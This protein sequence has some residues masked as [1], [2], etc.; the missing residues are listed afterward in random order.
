MYVFVGPCLSVIT[1]QSI[2]FDIAVSFFSK[3]NRSNKVYCYNGTGGLYVSI[4]NNINLFFKFLV[5]II[6][7]RRN[8]KCLYLT[9]SRSLQGFLRDF[10]FVICCKVFGIK[11]V[12]HLH[13]ADF[14]S[15][16]NSL[17]LILRWFV[18][19]VYSNIE[20]SIVG[21]PSMVE[22]YNLYPKMETAVVS[23]CFIPFS[24]EVPERK[25]NSG[26][27]LK[28]L[29][30]SN[31]MVSKGIFELIDAVDQLVKDG[32]EISLDI[33]GAPMA[34]E[35]CSKR[36]VWSKF[37]SKINGCPFIR[38][39]GTV[40]GEA[41]EKLL[42]NSDLFALPSYYKTESQ[43]ISIIE[44]IA[45]GCV[46]VCSRHNYLSEMVNENN[47][48][49]FD[50]RSSL[51]ISDLLCSL[52]CD[53]S[54]FNDISAYNIQYASKHYTMSNYLLKIDEVLRSV[55]GNEP[56]LSQKKTDHSILMQGKDSQDP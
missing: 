24:I 21:L 2:A 30:L 20:M 14:K 40:S 36:E 27:E 4:V 22:Q 17:P 54:T 34:D 3:H 43:P 39:H 7:H 48:Y 49:L 53:R 19:F 9:T 28:V 41:K 31:L 6:R 1:G 11:V 18:D 32:Y 8:V 45:A 38:Y 51:S 55:C 42:F 29:F 46:I 56:S 52:H 47:G 33:A 25:F 16:R 5:Y 37:V 12:N 50:K 35:Y 23:N 44:A 26:G 15:F 13:G 10:L